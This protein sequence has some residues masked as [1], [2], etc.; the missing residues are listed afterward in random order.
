VVIIPID[1]EPFPKPHLHG[2]ERHAGNVAGVDDAGRIRIA[3]PDAALIP[4]RTRDLAR[5]PN[6]FVRQTNN[7][8][9]ETGL[10]PKERG[11]G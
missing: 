3:E 8:A 6:S 7:P 1:V 2:L 9:R 11:V 4:K 10:E 5:G